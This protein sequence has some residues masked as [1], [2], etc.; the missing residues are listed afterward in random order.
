MRISTEN[1]VA[2]PTAIDVT[3]ISDKTPSLVYTKQ[4][5]PAGVESREALKRTTRFKRVGDRVIIAQSYRLRK[6]RGR[7]FVFSSSR[8]IFDTK[9]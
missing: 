4:T 8:Q 3:F 5:S 9:R 7:Y 1:K 2:S 6:S